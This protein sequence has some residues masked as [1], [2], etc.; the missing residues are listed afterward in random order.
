M[1]NGSI[2]SSSHVSSTTKNVSEILPSVEIREKP[3][4][5]LAPEK[6][7]S[8]NSSIKQSKTIDSKAFKSD[9]LPSYLSSSKAQVTEEE[10][11][12][13]TEA[14]LKEAAEVDDA[15]VEDE[16]PPPLAGVNVMNIILVAAE[17]APW[18]KTGNIPFNR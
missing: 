14:D 11:E 13:S 12:N 6:A 10:E 2:P 15:A 16:K 4:L 9:V 17:C 7:S 5:Y 18:S 3:E 1:T 8:N